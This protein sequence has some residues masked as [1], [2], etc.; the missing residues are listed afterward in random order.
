MIQGFCFK[1]FSVEKFLQLLLFL[2]VAR[3]S[4]EKFLSEQPFDLQTQTYHERLRSERPAMPPGRT[5]PDWVP[6]QLFARQKSRKSTVPS[7][8]SKKTSHQC[9]QRSK[10]R[11]E[12]VCTDKGTEITVDVEFS[13]R[14]ER[15][16]TFFSI[17]AGREAPRSCLLQSRTMPVCLCKPS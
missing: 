11:Q 1:Q 14:Y 4:T 17:S 3:A 7:K 5:G 10:S 16:T 9:F 13:N 15:L 8:T 6:T 12:Y 2:D